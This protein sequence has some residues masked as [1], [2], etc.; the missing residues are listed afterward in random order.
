MKKNQLSYRKEREVGGKV[1]NLQMSR[2]GTPIKIFFCLHF[3]GTTANFIL[4]HNQTMDPQTSETRLM[5]L[6]ELVREEKSSFL[7]KRREEEAQYGQARDFLLGRSLYDKYEYTC[8]IQI[9][10]DEW[11]KSNILF[12]V[13]VC[14]EEFLTGMWKGE[15]RCG[16]VVEFNVS[17][18]TYERN[19][20]LRIVFNAPKSIDTDWTNIELCI[21]EKV[22]SCIKECC[23]GRK[24]SSNLVLV[25]YNRKVH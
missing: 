15:R 10:P 4:C 9:P 14:I 11:D 3:V 23:T 7:D 18:M 6:I 17:N 21:T 13:A 8:V 5:E 22:K 12:T 2:S 19:K 1:K 20:M 16:L 25:S 24:L